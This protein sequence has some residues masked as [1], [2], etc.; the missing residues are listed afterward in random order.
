MNHKLLTYEEAVQWLK[1]HPDHQDLVYHC[2]YDDPLESAAERFSNSE[3]WKAIKHLLRKHIPGKVLDI[4]AG[5]GIASYAFAKAGCSVTA[6]EPDPSSLIGAKAI[7][8]LVAQANLPIEIVQEYGERLPFQNNYFDVVFARAV[9]HHAQ[10]L[11]QF[12]K[13]VARVLRR[14]GVFIATREHV[15]SRKEDLQLF[16]DSH[17]LHFLYGGE[18]AYLL[19]E[20]TDAISSAGLKLQKVMG[21]YD[22][23]LNYAPM[24]QQDF[25]SMT[26]SMLTHFRIGTKLSSLLASQELIQQFYGRHLSKK[27][28]TPGR[29]FSFL[30]FKN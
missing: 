19:Q 29:H 23:V 28:D 2:Y 26:T 30:A 9:L 12:C 16:F 27:L 8:D 24:T 1:N 7:R 18:N 14:D 15:I 13:E 25:Q 6:L 17:A 3:E 11:K 22:N 10:D 4:G 20:Y 5:R 21:H